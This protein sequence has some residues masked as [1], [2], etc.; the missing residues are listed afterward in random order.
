[1]KI[2]YQ[3]R[4]PN[5]WIGGDSMKLQKIMEGVKSLGIE[6]DFSH[7]VNEERAKDFDI[8]HCFN[9][10]M[11]WTKQ[12]LNNAKM[13]NKPV[14]ISSIFHPSEGCYSYVEQKGFVEYAKAVIV[15]SQ[16]EQD[17]MKEKLDLSNETMEKF[18]ILPNG[19]DDMFFDVASNKSRHYVMAAGRFE[20]LKNF[21]AVAKATNELN[22]PFLIVGPLSSP[23]YLDQVKQANP[24]TVYIENVSRYWMP[25]FYKHAKVF[26]VLSDWEVFSYTLLEAG[27]SGCNCVYSNQALG[28][29]DLPYIKVAD[30]KDQ[31]DIVNKIKESW[32]L[33][34][35]LEFSNMLREKFTW[36]KHCEKMKE[37]YE[38]I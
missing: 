9:L 13:Y 10:S 31:P 12:Q 8:V 18:H 19:I 5:S 26:C 15:M 14:V 37:I 1:M 17:L 29:K 35:N 23:E 6:T 11:D 34:N 27:A 28:G 32:G 22:L 7:R 33:E 2:L 38:S 16:A 25:H 4:D 21:L 24:R 36:P 3:N 30:I 20:H